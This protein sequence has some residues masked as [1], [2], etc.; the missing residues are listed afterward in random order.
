M[1]KIDLMERLKDRFDQKDRS[2]LLCIKFL[3][4]FW[5]NVIMR[6]ESYI[7]VEMVEISN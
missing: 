7:F 2:F 5:N 4:L 6:N 1:K 3:E